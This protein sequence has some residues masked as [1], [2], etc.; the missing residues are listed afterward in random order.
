MQISAV[1]PVYNSAPILP[2]LIDRLEP[3]LAAAATDFEIILVNDASQDGSWEVIRGLVEAYP[4]L[5]AI[6]LMRNYGQHNALLC[7]IR[8]ARYEL[9]VTLDDDLQHPPEEIPA[10][11]AE[12]ERGYDVVYGTPRQEQH[13]LWR[14]LASRLT[15]LAFKSAMGVD[16]ARDVS[17]FRVF[18]TPIREA[19][20]A[21]QGPFASIDV[22]LTWGSTCFSA[23]PV[24][25]APRQA[26]VSNYTFRKLI[27]HALNMLTGFSVLP[28]RLATWVG[29][30]FATFGA[31]VL[32]YVLLV[33]LFVGR[34]VQGF[35]FLAS[36]IAV[37]SGAQ[38]LSLGIMGEYL[39][40]MHFRLMLK[41]AYVVQEQLGSQDPD[42]N[43]P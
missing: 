2:H 12:L 36:I 11:L 41:P 9:I 10:L 22:L 5:R 14:N 23:V 33:Y 8:A 20:A 16:I 43:D 42:P 27:S 29:L 39:A 25:H 26:G 3:E 19:F 21:Y 40:R 4:C 1:I 17:A 24:N 15:K 37:F 30:G 38:L 6:N 13:N 28:L 7:G 18:R 34:A 32:I 31:L 35:A